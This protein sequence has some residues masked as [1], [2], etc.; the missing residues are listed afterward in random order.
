MLL[1]AERIHAQQ[2]LY[3]GLINETAPRADLLERADAIA[4]RIAKFDGA[5]LAA[6]KRALDEIP[7]AVRSWREAFDAG[8][9][10]NREIKATSNSATLLLERFQRGQR[11]LGQGS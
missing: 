2:A 3:W 1:T 7:L 10:Y 6:C 4:A 5:T 8:A 11:N 9:R